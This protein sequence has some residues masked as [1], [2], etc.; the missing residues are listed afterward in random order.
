MYHRTGYSSMYFGAHNSVN[1]D[2]APEVL[3]TGGT[4]DFSPEVLGKDRFEIARLLEQHICK[5]EKSKSFFMSLP[6]I[7]ML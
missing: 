7:L 4:E 6:H 1:D 2:A 5:R 3:C